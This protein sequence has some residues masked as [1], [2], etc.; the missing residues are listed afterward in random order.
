LFVRELGAVPVAL[1]KALKVKESE[2]PDE[3]L[4]AVDVR[5]TVVPD[6]DDTVPTAPP[7]VTS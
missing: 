2:E 6:T 4:D 5:V 3:F 1:G 7:A